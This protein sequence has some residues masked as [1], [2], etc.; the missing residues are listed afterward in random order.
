LMN[1][2]NARTT[3]AETGTR[4]NDD[5]QIETAPVRDRGPFAFCLPRARSFVSDS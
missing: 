4:P 5:A 1:V 3:A 2:S